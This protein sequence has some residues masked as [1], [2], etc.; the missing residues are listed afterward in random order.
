MDVTNEGQTDGA[1]S[2]L[3][4]PIKA[5]SRVP[6]AREA[7][8]AFSDTG[9]FLPC[10]IITSYDAQYRIPTRFWWACS[11]SRDFLNPQS[12]LLV[13]LHDL[14]QAFFCSIV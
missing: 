4:K 11:V 13:S 5:R 7:R 8:P 14:Y 6:L 2:F 3:R 9:L 12:R 10:T 1:S